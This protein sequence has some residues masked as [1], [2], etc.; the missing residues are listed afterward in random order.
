MN[1]ATT[2]AP[3]PTA[4]DSK[5]QRSVLVTYFALSLVPLILGWVCIKEFGVNLPI[6]DEWSLIDF[7]LKAEN[8]SI[9]FRDI[10]ALHNEHR[11]ASLRLIS[12]PIHYFSS[13]WQS[14]TR[15][16]L[17][18]VMSVMAYFLLIWIIL[19]SPGNP[20]KGDTL[21]S[22]LQAPHAFGL[23]IFITSLLFFF[24]SQYE[25]WLWGFQLPWFLINFLL[26]ASVL[27]LQYFATTK[28]TLFFGLSL[29]AC[30]VASFTLAQGIFLWFAC[31]PML[32]SNL[33]SQR[34]RF[35]YVSLWMMISVLTAAIYAIGYRKPAGHPST[36]TIFQKPFVGL[37]FFL[38]QIGGF[39][40]KVETSNLV[41]GLLIL[42]GFIS[43]SLICLNQ[44]DEAHDASLPWISIGLFPIAF[45]IMT[46]VGRVGMGTN[47]AFSSRYAT[48]SLLLP[49][50]VVQLLRIIFVHPTLSKRLKPVFLFIL[51]LAGFLFSSLIV[52]F[53]RGISKA[54]STMLDRHRA[55][56][57]LELFTRIEYSVAHQCV[58]TYIHPASEIPVGILQKVDNQPSSVETSLNGNNI[59][60]SFDALTYVETPKQKFLTASGWAFSEANPGVVLFSLDGGQSFFTVENV[61]NQRQDVAEAYASDDYLFTGW[62]ANIEIDKV[63]QTANSL[64]AYFYD[65]NNETFFEL[66]NKPIPAFHPKSQ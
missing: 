46:T 25:N 54:Q 64:T 21:T 14:K 36:T 49:I 60:G 31:L 42:L 11:I 10:F 16:F 22:A 2:L 1:Q 35:R 58:A 23:S 19:K 50:C 28:R 9:S 30:L 38:N 63:P 8:S 55:Q 45:S 65:L 37:D 66:G 62:Q 4:D 20:R 39:L 61:N 33:L 18:Y 41:L 5:K 7:L 57:C 56:A 29:L 51:F 40:G 53:E 44:R 27:S 47:I 17:G 32:W 34:E 15:M 24:P 12:L 59:A 3:Q 43:L 48:V 52:G 13:D 26:I 6:A